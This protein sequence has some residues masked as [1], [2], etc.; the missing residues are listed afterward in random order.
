VNSKQSATEKS[1][2]Q[3]MAEINA[4]FEEIYTDTKDKVELTLTALSDTVDNYFEKEAEDAKAQFE[5]NVEEKLDEIYG[6]TVVD[7]WIFGEDTEAIEKVFEEENAI[8]IKT[9]DGVLDKIAQGIAD[10]LNHTLKIIADGRKKSDDY[11]NSLDKK[12][13]QLAKDA[14]D[15]YNDQYNSLE[16]SVYEKEDELAQGLA[17]AYKENVDSLRETFD[18]IK[19]SVSAGWI[20][21][22]LNAIWGIIKTIM[23]LFEMLFQLLSAVVEAIQTIL[24]DPIGFLSNLFNGVKKGLDNFVSNI[25]THL[26]TGLVEWLTGSLGGVGIGFRGV[27]RNPMGR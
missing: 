13:Q 26:L 10:A 22:A 1:D 24:D 3:M 16:D 14:Y 15:N 19:E 9:M 18:E 7:D 6:W 17:D 21:A 23:K 11:Y 25:K 27:R 5:E 2:E 4:K 8:F 20:G 12:Q